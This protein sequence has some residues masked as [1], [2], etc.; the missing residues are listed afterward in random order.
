M[1]LGFGIR[2]ILM[3]RQPPSVGFQGKS[4][5]LMEE[6]ENHNVGIRALKYF[7]ILTTAE[8]KSPFINLH[9]VMQDFNA[10]FNTYER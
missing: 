5:S 3:L 7:S 6:R 2:L 10:I 8:G 1:Y 9:D 4:M